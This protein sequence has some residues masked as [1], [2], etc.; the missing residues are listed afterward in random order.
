[1]MNLFIFLFFFSSFSLISLLPHGDRDSFFSP[2]LEVSPSLLYH[3]PFFPFSSLSL[4]H[5]LTFS[6]SLLLVAT[7]RNHVYAPQR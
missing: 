6:T 5:L 2:C 7:P 3:P 4:L 1:M